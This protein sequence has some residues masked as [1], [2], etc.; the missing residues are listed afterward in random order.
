MK[1][2]R[3]RLVVLAAAGLALATAGLLALA[4]QPEAPTPEYPPP[5]DR[6]EAWRQD[7]AYLRDEFTKV[8]RSFSAEASK[9]FQDLLGRLHEEIPSLS[10]NELVVGITRAVAASGNAHTRTYL[11][12]NASYLRRLPIRWYWF[13]DGLFVVRA[14]EDHRHTLGARVVAINGIPPERLRQDMRDLIPGSDSW[15]AY[16]STYFLNSPELLNGMKVLA[17]AGAVPI[18]FQRDGD[19]TLTLILAPLALEDRKEPYEAWRDL[20][21]LST[22]NGDGH[23]WV[24]VLPEDS[25]PLYLQRPDHACSYRYFERERLLY[26]QVT[27][28]ASDQ[29]CSQAELAESVAALADSISPAAV[30]FDLRF[31]TGGDYRETAK[32]TEGLPEWFE[33]ARSIYIVT[34]PATFSAGIVSA[35]RLKHFSGARAVV[36]GEPAGD[37]LTMW[38]EGPTFVL[39]NSR[40]RVKAATAFHDFAEGRFEPGKTFLM[41]LFYRVPAGDLDVDWPVVTTFPEYMSGHDPVLEA[42]VSQQSST[43]IHP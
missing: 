12:R 42:I 13:A 20:S 43:R 14:T 27:R 23:A 41:D 30:V 1:Y 29:I 28:N 32:V 38:S 5:R 2:T 39:P 17:G 7:I 37:G 10:D 34:G 8:D 3:T 36:V 40:L 24:H 21:P 31:N 26:L 22:G 15:V 11:M 4:T 16:K 33:S 25:L 6:D 18:T 35:A 9:R 19:T